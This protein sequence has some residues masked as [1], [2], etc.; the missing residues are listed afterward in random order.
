M[1]LAMQGIELPELVDQ[2]GHIV[3]VPLAKLS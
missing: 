1:L 2:G 3:E